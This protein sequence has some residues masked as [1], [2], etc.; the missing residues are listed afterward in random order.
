MIP[1]K[2]IIPTGQ[3]RQ[4]ILYGTDSLHDKNIGS[5]L[6]L[7]LKEAL[8]ICSGKFMVVINVMIIPYGQQCSRRPDATDRY[9]V[10]VSK[11]IIN[12]QHTLLI[13]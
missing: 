12:M 9:M 1:D 13:V 7:S 4:V 2:R 6:W 10:V 8:N 5:N 3:T 11:P